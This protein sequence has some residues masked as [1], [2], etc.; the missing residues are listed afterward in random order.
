MTTLSITSWRISH[1]LWMSGRNSLKKD[2]DVERLRKTTL[3][4][5]SE[6]LERQSVTKKSH[7]VSVRSIMMMAI[8][9]NNFS[10]WASRVIA[11]SSISMSSCIDA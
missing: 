9:K 8:S 3:P 7:L 2:I 4:N 11:D 6:N 1:N 5:S 10:R